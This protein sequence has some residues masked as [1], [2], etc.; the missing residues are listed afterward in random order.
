M[1][2]IPL[3]P[4]GGVGCA[5]QA[6]FSLRYWDQNCDPVRSRRFRR[7]PAEFGAA[8]GIR[9]TGFLGCLP[10]TPHRKRLSLFLIGDQ[11]A[12]I[13]VGP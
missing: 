12:I 6:G 9:A 8:S 7:N 5:G 1:V 3:L 4:R 11:I 10:A 2:Y 13:A